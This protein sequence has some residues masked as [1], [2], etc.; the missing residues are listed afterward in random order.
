LDYES[1]AEAV[2]KGQNLCIERIRRCL[3][4]WCEQLHT[5]WLGVR[6]EVS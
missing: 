1:K 5:M 6:V 4:A 2:F 3:P